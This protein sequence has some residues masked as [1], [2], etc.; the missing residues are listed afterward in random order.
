[1]S[2]GFLRV[3]KYRI[4]A[5]HQFKTTLTAISNNHSSVASI[6][7]TLLVTHLLCWFWFYIHFWRNPGTAII[8]HRCMAD[9]IIIKF[10]LTLGRCPRLRPHV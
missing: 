10:T 1:M 8:K 3:R 9:F 4:R 6:F 7:T 5:P 2:K